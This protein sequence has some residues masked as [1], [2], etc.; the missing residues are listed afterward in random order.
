MKPTS[1][2]VL[3][4]GEAKKL[5]KLLTKVSRSKRLNAAV[6]RSAR[7][8][9]ERLEKSIS[10]VSRAEIFRIR[11]SE[12]LGYVK[13]LISAVS[14]FREIAPYVRAVMEKK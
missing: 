6:K 11:L 8:Q 7:L 12:F 5:A 10:S 13:V 9:S 14:V 2:V 3:P 1:E 4:I